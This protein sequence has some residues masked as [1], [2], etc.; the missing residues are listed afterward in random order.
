MPL[1]VVKYLEELEGSNILNMKVNN[2]DNIAFSLIFIHKH[3]MPSLNYT[4]LNKQWEI[5]DVSNGIGVRQ[6]VP[7][8]SIYLFPL[9]RD[10]KIIEFWNPSATAICSMSN[11]LLHE[12]LGE[13]SF[14][15]IKFGMAIERKDSNGVNKGMVHTDDMNTSVSVLRDLQATNSLDDILNNNLDDIRNSIEK[16]NFHREKITHQ[17]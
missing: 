4:H 14:D 5:F 16:S 7:N 8:K 1:D 9:S 10:E 12:S 11:Y 2:G 6:S 15:D 3:D 13:K 17:I